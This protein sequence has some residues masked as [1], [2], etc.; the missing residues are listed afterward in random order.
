MRAVIFAAASVLALSP[1]AYAQYGNPDIYKT[2]PPA[3]APAPPPTYNVPPTGTPGST[4]PRSAVPSDTAPVGAPAN[5]RL[6]PN[7]CGTP[8]EPKACPPIPR[9]AMG[10]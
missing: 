7:N 4:V 8:D 3:A 5:T 10:H 1:V 2:P 6:D 9:R